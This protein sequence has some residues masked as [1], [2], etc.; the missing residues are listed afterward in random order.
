MTMFS[1]F[2]LNCLNGNMNNFHRKWWTTIIY[3]YTFAIYISGD[4]HI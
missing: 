1:T 3:F 2:V 4:C